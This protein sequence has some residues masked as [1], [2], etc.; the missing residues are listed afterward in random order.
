MAACPLRPAR[1]VAAL[2]ILLA[3]ILGASRSILA[4][5]PS[6]DLILY[7]G[8]IFTSDAAH[9]YVQALAIRGERI[10]ATG[11]S[12]KMLALRGPAT[13]TLDLGGRTVIPGINDAHVHLDISPTSV[14]LP[15]HGRNPTRDQVLSAISASVHQTPPGSLL[16]ATVASAVYFDPQM[17]RSTLDSVAPNNP[18]M[19]IT[20]TG[21]AAF[22]NS[23]ALRKFGIREDQP[24]PLGGKFER[25]PDGKLNGIVREYAL[26]NLERQLADAASDADALKQLQS[27][28]DQASKFGITTIQDMSNMM[29]PDRAVMLLQKLPTTIRVRVVRMPGT[30]PA[31]R[32]AQE[33]RPAPHAAASL[34]AVN[35]TKW[36]LDGTPLE[37]TFASRESRASDLSSPKTARRHPA[38]RWKP[39]LATSACSSLSRS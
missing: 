13:R 39:Y 6:A 19:L 4:Q 38:T 1:V 25:G 18:V 26:M 30:T 34:I 27:Q 3:S 14:E 22:L 5:S 2:C 17:T 31:G 24:D 11:D 35:G 28:L 15:L 36:L 33:G 9:P 8:K 29:P 12:V 10:L 21:H 16:T 37:G 20:F 23:A 7:N 32:N